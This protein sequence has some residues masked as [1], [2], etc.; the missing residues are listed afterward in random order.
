[1]SETKATYSCRQNRLC[2][3]AKHSKLT[4]LYGVI[5][6]GRLFTGKM[7]F[8]FCYSVMTDAILIQNVVQRNG[9]ILMS[10]QSTQLT[11]FLI[12]M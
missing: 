9:K 7:Y 11:L 10:T 4:Y 2:D 3:H 5:Q 6:H 12:Y 1:M 8:L